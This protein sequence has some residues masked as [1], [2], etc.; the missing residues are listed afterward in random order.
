M[1]AKEG[2][3]KAFFSFGFLLENITELSDK[4]LNTQYK[5]IILFKKNLPHT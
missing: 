3:A 1:I 4:F 5:L 2:E